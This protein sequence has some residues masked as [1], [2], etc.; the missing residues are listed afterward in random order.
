MDYIIGTGWWCDGSGTHLHSRY[1]KGV[2]KATRQKD[3]FELWYRAVKK[4]TT[5][6]KIV[7]IDSNSP[8]VPEF[9]KKRDVQVYSLSKNWGPGRRGTL[10]G[11]LSGWDRGILTAASIA[12]LDNAAY[13]VYL[14]QDCL[15]KGK[16]IIEHAIS[17]FD[18]D[19]MILVGDG[20]GTPDP[21]Q[22]SL[23]IIKHEYIPTFINKEMSAT[24]K[25]LRTSAEKRYFS[26]YQKH[27]Q[28][29]PF[30]GGRHRPIKWNNRFV[31]AQHLNKH[32]LNQFKKIIK[33]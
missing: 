28:F 8:V 29:L 25:F 9:D 24:P 3:F 4:Y 21:I 12:Y 16:G 10:D 5:P 13:F 15:V 23:I 22:Q 18:K 17:K 32:E 20:E 19:K 27:L 33:K 31:Y 6:R 14:E 30:E 1:Q 2:D 7:V 11:K 26:H